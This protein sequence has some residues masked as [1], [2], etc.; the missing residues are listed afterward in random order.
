[1]SVGRGLGVRTVARGQSSRRAIGASRTMIPAG[2]EWLA[3]RWDKNEAF[4]ACD[5]VARSPAVG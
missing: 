4:A 2:K 5:R 3:N 1:M